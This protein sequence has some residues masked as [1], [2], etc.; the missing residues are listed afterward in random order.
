MPTVKRMDR[1]LASIQA[2]TY[3]P[4]DFIIADAKDSDM[5]LGTGVA[6]PELDSAGRPTGRML[7]LAIYR[8]GMERMVESDAI[9]IM[10]TSLSSGEDLSRKG[11]F[12]RSEVTPAIRLNDGSDIWHWRGAN[13]RHLPTVPFRTARLDRVRPI[14]DLGLYALTF[15][16]DLD[17]DRR[18]LDAYAAFRDEASAQGVRHFLEVFNPQFPVEAP[19]TDF[20]TYNNDAIARCLAGVSR[21]DRPVFLK[22][23]YNGPRATEELASYDPGNLIVGILGGASSTTRDT[24]E[25]V[26]QAERHGAR[27]ALFGRKIFFAEDPVGIVRAMRRVIEEGLSSEEATR[28]YHDELGKDGLRPKMPLAEDLELTDPVLKP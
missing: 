3:R 1:K 21:L 26:K 15:F 19:G 9:D 11:V 14:A 22:V 10:L 13:Y 24:L 6:G 25:M 18:S 17:Q 27:V 12:A 23:V 20:A 28:A 16:N 7:P 8:A 5:A 4:A 2:G